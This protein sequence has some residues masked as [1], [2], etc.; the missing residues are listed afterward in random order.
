MESSKNTYFYIEH[1][2]GSEAVVS[3]LFENYVQAMW[4]GEE[5]TLFGIILEG[6]EGKLETDFLAIKNSLKLEK[7]SLH[8]TD[9]ID[10]EEYQIPF[11]F[12]IE[13]FYI[14]TINS[15]STIPEDLIPIYL[16]AESAFGSGEH[17]TTATCIQ[18]IVEI[19]DTPISS[20]LDIGCGTGVLSLAIALLS[21]AK[22]YA[23]DID[24]N[25]VLSAKKNCTLNQVSN[26]EVLLAD[27]LNHPKIQSNAPFDLVVAN[28]H[29]NPLCNLAGAISSVL[30]PGSTVVIS[31]FL[32]D[33]KDQVNRCFLEKGL[34]IISEVQRGNWCT[35]VFHRLSH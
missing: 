18:E 10:Q 32:S 4:W 29:A 22:V 5:H 19:C 17:E 24:T 14:T 6:M 30:R 1:L 21:Q 35:T 3:E 26:I 9:V 31:G 23:S 12:T 28:I 11:P 13:P 25:A 15:Y 16:D 34:S 27:G 20:A 7:A 33:Q 8:F 2:N